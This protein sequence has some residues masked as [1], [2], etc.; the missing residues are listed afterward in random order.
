M[1]TS[2][3]AKFSWSQLRFFYPFACLTL[4]SRSRAMALRQYQFILLSNGGTCVWTTGPGLHPRVRRPQ[5]VDRNFIA[6]T[7]QPPSHTWHIATQITGADE[8][9][10]QGQKTHRWATH[11]AHWHTDYRCWWGSKTRTEDPQVSHTHGTLTN[12]L[13]VLMRV[14]DKD[15]RPT[16]EPHTRHIATQ[17]TDADEGQRQGLKTHRWAWDK[18]VRG[19]WCVFRTVL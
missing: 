13:Q 4:H 3:A 2:L 14:K 11:T 15:R 17:I 16:G 10:R 8:G 6:Q 1:N 7:T 5:P 9:Q 12:R 19:I 18:Q